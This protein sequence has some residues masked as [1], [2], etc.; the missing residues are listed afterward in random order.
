MDNKPIH[1][2]WQNIEEIPANTELS[3]QISKDLKKLG[4][5]FV[6]TTIMYAYMQSIGMVNDHE[7]NCFRYEQIKKDR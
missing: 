5:T 7:V 3:N 1:N 4:F 2:S 6:G